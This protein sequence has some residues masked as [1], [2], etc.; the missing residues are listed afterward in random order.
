MSYGSSIDN[1]IA[2]L[3]KYGKD[4]S[5]NIHVIKYE[6]VTPDLYMLCFRTYGNDGNEYY[7]AAL[8]FDYMNTITYAKSTIKN[9]FAKVIEF[10]APEEKQKGRTELE[11]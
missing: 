6:S 10:I 5:K 8:K 9:N 7:F 4:L 11:K 3:D 2:S 1:F